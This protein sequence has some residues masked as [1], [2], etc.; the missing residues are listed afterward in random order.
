M[1]PADLRPGHRIATADLGGFTVIADPYS[2]IE[3]AEQEGCPELGRIYVDVEP[4]DKST[5][6]DPDNL[7]AATGAE[8]FWWLGSSPLRYRLTFLPDTDVRIEGE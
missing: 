3:Y 5:R 1:S 8:A 7:P 6:W 2:D 4:D